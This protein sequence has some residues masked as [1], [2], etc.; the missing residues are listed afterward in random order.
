MFAPSLVL[1]AKDE[2]A[3]LRDL[4]DSEISWLQDA[5]S[6]NI[7]TTEEESALS[8]WRTYRVLLMRVDI[9]QAPN[10]SWPSKPNT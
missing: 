10:I 8:E 3:K 1:L 5:V 4:A 2:K 7:A 9:E 6:E